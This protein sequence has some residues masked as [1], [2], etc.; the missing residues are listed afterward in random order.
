MECEE[1]RC[2]VVLGMLCSVCWCWNCLLGVVMREMSR[3]ESVIV[4]V[5]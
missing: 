5:M 4:M 1:Q 2:G 3:E